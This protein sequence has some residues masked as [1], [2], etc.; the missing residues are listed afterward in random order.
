MLKFW[1]RAFTSFCQDAHRRNQFI[2]TSR[3]VESWEKKLAIPYAPFPSSSI[4]DHTGYQ[5]KHKINVLGKLVSG[6][7]LRKRPKRHKVGFQNFLIVIVEAVDKLSDD[8][9]ELIIVVSLLF[10]CAPGC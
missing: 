3:N 10:T 2:L 9:W 4:A 1:I 8:D 7:I 6:H 5:A